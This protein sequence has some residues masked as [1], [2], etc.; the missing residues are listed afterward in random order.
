MRTVP[1]SFLAVMATSYWLYQSLG[2]KMG[3]EQRNRGMVFRYFAVDTAIRVN[4]IRQF[5]YY[6]DPRSRERRQRREAFTDHAM[7]ALLYA[8]YADVVFSAE[9]LGARPVQPRQLSRTIR[10]GLP[11]GGITA[12]RKG[13][14]GVKSNTI[15][16]FIFTAGLK[17]VI[18]V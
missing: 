11:N 15:S 13:I 3:S 10:N 7:H 16:W 2:V 5:R 9:G 18:E 17:T 14:R 1:F 12:S 8:E 6:T 4:N